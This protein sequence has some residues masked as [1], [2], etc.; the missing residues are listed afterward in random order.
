MTIWR[1]RTA[2]WIIQ[3]KNAHSQYVI[4][5]GFLS[6]NDCTKAPRYYVMS[7]LPFLFQ[8]SYY[9]PFRNWVSCLLLL[10]LSPLHS[11]ATISVVVAILTINMT[12]IAL[13]LILP[14]LLRVSIFTSSSF[15]YY[16]FYYPYHAAVAAYAC[17]TTIH[18]H[19]YNKCIAIHKQFMSRQFLKYTGY[20]QKNGAL[21]KV[22][23]KFISHL[24][25]A[26]PTPSAAATV[27]VSHVLPVVR[28]SCL[29]RDQFPKWRHS[30]K[31]ISVCSF[32]RCDYS[33]A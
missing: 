16:Y 18:Y 14:L 26:Q 8:Y 6:N 32:L 4:V 17:G 12:K 21:S 30:W 10:L 13:L 22:N 3:D 11:L 2:C 33:A 1:P 5:T 29:L 9:T 27:Q 25:R 31:R 15:R 7:T 23:K 24:T 28:F 19:I 20:T